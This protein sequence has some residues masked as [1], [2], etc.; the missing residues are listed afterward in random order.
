M[1]RVLTPLIFAVVLLFLSFPHAFAQFTSP[2]YQS[3]ETFFGVG[4]DLD[5][6][7]TN[8]K[9]QSS[10]GALGVGHSSVP[11]SFIQGN[12]N[13]SSATTSSLGSSFG[14]SVTS[15]HL[16]VIALG[17]NDSNPNN[18]SVSD[19]LG[20]SYSYAVSRSDVLGTGNYSTRIAWGVAPSTG[21]DTVTLSIGGAGDD[22]VRL[23][24]HEYS[25]ANAIDVTASATG[26]SATLDTGFATTNHAN[27]LIF[28]WMISNAGVTSPGSGFTLRET[29]GSES[30]MDKTV[31]LAGSY[32]VTAPTTSSNWSALMATFYMSNSTYY[33][34]YSGFL[35][36]NEPFLE[37]GINTSLADLGVLDSTAT[38]TASANFYVRAYTSSGYTVASV[39]QP[40]KTNT[41]LTLAAKTSLGPPIIG[42]EEFGM[43]LVANTLPA[44]FGANPTK[45]PDATFAEGKAATGYNTTNQ[46]KYNAGDVI[47]NTSDN[48]WGQTTYTIS[49]IG[50]ITS[51]TRA[52]QYSMVQDLV[53]VPTY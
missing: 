21:A 35:T 37:M 33:Q 20:T 36:P 40:P 34:A 6:S 12:Q 24:I 30:T 11:A 47:A 10:A 9:A 17:A 46:F 25:G 22:F 32:N 29:S 27:E 41:G 43:N 39:S 28:G 3:N 18:I 53:V 26:T 52:G 45:L 1:N 8:Y 48:G 2:N 50:N 7:S 15:G 16:I 51:I 14:S 19:S 31:D 5:S 42:T 13:F 44:T 49:Y 4:G 23:L 38:K